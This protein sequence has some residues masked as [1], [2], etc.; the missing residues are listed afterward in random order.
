MLISSWHVMVCVRRERLGSVGLMRLLQRF[1][2]MR[3]PAVILVLPEI[4]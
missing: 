1:M 4:P 3:D 2:L